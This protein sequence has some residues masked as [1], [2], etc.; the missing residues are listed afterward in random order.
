MVEIFC[1]S[2]PSWRSS[3][4][5]KCELMSWVLP[6]NTSLPMITIPAVLDMTPTSYRN[7]ALSGNRAKSHVEFAATHKKGALRVAANEMALVVLEFCPA[8]RT[9]LP[10]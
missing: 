3:V 1:T 2:T 7:K 6:D 4:Q 10:P 8:K 9:A 5:K